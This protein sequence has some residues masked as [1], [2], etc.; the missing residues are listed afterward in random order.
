MPRIARSSP[1]PLDGLRA[2]F[3]AEYLPALRY[4]TV[5]STAIAVPQVLVITDSDEVPTRQ[6]SRGADRVRV[7]HAAGNR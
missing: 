7:A 2:M 4:I 1:V 6:L 5:D 3:E